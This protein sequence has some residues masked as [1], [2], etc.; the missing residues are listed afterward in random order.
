MRRGAV[1]ERRQ[2]WRLVAPWLLV[3]VLGLCLPGLLAR[4]C[5]RPWAGAL[6]LPPLLVLLLLLA[7]RRCTALHLLP[8]LHASRCC[9]RLILP[10]AT[11]ALVPHLQHRMLPQLLP[12]LLLAL[13]QRLRQSFSAL[14][15]LLLL[16]LLLLA[17]PRG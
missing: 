1:W 7:V 17:S 5:E 4:G 16:A 12:W 3:L 13:Q 15:G 11:T 9:W 2:L 10:P 6:L 8:L 14:P